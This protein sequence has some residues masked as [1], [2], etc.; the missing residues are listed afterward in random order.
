MSATFKLAAKKKYSQND[1]RKLMHEQKPKAQQ[2]QQKKIDSPL[3][4]Y[5]FLNFINES[6][7]T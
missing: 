3:A 5:P 6:K 7:I 1:L 2:Q 4:K